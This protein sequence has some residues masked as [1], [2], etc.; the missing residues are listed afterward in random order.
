MVPS[1]RSAV[2]CA[3]PALMLVT[4]VTPSTVRG[5]SLS[6][7]VPSPSCPEPLP[8]QART[9]PSLTS[10]RLWVRPAEMPTTAAEPT[11]GTGDSDV[12]V[13]PLPS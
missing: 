5:T 11:T 4:L 2:L 7:V 12:V 13:V 1:A 9:L 10:A 8:P 6:V 3:P